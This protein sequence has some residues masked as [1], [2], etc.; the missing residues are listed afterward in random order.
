MGEIVAYRCFVNPHFPRIKQ[1]WK[2][3]L[4]AQSYY[5][6]EASSW[7]IGLT[8][9]PEITLKLLLLPFDLNRYSSRFVSKW[10]GS[11]P[12]QI[13]SFPKRVIL[14]SGAKVC[15]SLQWSFSV[16]HLMVAPVW[17]VEGKG[18]ASGGGGGRG[19]GAGGPLRHESLAEMVASSSVLSSSSQ[20]SEKSKVLRQRRAAGFRYEPQD[21]SK[22][23]VRRLSLV[24]SDC[25]IGL[26][27]LPVTRKQVLLKFKSVDFDNRVINSFF[28][29]RGSDWVRV[30]FSS[31]YSTQRLEWFP[32]LSF[33]LCSQHN[34]Q[35]LCI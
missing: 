5:I 15:S 26:V 31:L 16:R 4:S 19:G 7:R 18:G 1:I 14:G 3:C 2:A 8:C 20:R 22:S 30:S 29:L 23:R 32:S 35:T 17:E 28:G 33:L 6:P 27:E 12:A 25:F 34:S 21:W 13:V 10:T 24:C 11:R 9:L